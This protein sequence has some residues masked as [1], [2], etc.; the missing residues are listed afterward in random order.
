MTWLNLPDGNQIDTVLVRSVMLYKGKGIAVRDAQQRLAAYVKIEDHQKG[1]RA[2]DA[3]L[4]RV[5]NQR[6]GDIDW[7]FL[8]ETSSFPPIEAANSESPQ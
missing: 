2:R 7:T 6:S 8:S 3:I 4:L 1:E 5:K